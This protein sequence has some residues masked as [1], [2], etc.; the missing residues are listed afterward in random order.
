MPYEI[1]QRVMLKD[2]VALMGCH[3]EGVLVSVGYRDRDKLE[4][5]GSNLNKNVNNLLCASHLTEF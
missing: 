5:R 3:L 2:L 1:S 4:R